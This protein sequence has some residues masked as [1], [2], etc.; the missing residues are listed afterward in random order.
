AR[1]LLHPVEVG[2]GAKRL[3]RS[4]ELDDTGRRVSRQ[5]AHR[6]LQEGHELAVEGVPPG[7]TVQD[8]ACDPR[9]GRAL[10]ENSRLAHGITCSG[11]GRVEGHGE[12]L[13]LADTQGD[14]R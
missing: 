1:D 12:N 11:P 7:R 2:A 3:A 4:R 13:I 14:T 8:E 9:I 5:L 10:E 6:T